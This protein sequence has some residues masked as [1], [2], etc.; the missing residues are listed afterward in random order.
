M[1]VID[2]TFYPQLYIYLFYFSKSNQL[3]YRQ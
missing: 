2:I 3:P 1:V